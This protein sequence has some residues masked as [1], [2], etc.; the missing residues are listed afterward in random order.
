[1]TLLPAAIAS[2]L[3][4]DWTSETLARIAIVPQPMV[5]RELR[6]QGETLV[7]MHTVFAHGPGIGFVNRIERGF[8][9]LNLVVS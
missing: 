8:I 3:H 9:L 6:F 5:G 7:Q 4:H 2:A 1:M